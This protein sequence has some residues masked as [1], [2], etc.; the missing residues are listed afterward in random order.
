M[1][2]DTNLA[3]KALADP[4]RRSIIERLAA[5]PM[6]VRQINDGL[7]ISQPA[8]SQHLD[9]LKKAGLVRAEAQ[10][11][12]NVYSVDPAGLAVI[13]TWLDRHWSE[14]LL[15]YEALFDDGKD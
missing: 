11:A 13:R 15:N 12:S 8:V 5:K 1:S 3:F 6:T 2:Y 14:A 9:Q 10:G 4:T 7:T